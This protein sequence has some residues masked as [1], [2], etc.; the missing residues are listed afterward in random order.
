MRDSDNEPLEKI[1]YTDIC[2][3]YPTVNKY[4][5]YPIG[6]PKIIT[7][8]FEPISKT[9]QPYNGLIK[10]KVLP[11]R[12]LYHPLLPYRQGGKLLFPL[13]RTCADN[14]QHSQFAHNNE[15]RSITGTW[16]TLE[17]YKALQLGY[18]LVDT[19]EV[20]H[21]EKTEKYDRSTNPN[22]GL[23]RSYIDKFMGCYR[24]TKESIHQAVQGERRH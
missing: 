19:Y 16:V 20:W 13:C 2:S 3:L 10:A 9:E 11:P 21:Y 12:K 18:Q 6:H 7:E 24:R 14:H 22:G 5:E 23:L 4:G 15:E 8:N 1:H 17:L